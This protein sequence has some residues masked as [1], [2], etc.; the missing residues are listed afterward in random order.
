[1]QVALCLCA[2]SAHAD[3]PLD[4]EFRTSASHAELAR[5]A[6]A[7]SLSTR[8]ADT[9]RPIEVHALEDGVAMCSTETSY[10]D[11]IVVVMRMVSRG[12]PF[13]VTLAIDVPAS[14]SP[15]PA[16]YAALRV[17]KE[18]IESASLDALPTTSRPR[19]ETAVF[20]DPVKSSTTR[21]EKVVTAGVVMMTLA[22]IPTL[23]IG[24]A[25]A[26]STTYPGTSPV[27]P[28][29]PFVGMTV[30]SATYT[31]VADCNCGGD[32]A[33]SLFLSSLVNGVQIAGL[34]MVIVASASSKKPH[35]GRL[36]PTPLGIGGTF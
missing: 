34:V 13:V 4:A 8:V 25:I 24:G 29:V 20:V 21:I 16:D 35:V 33:L 26:G 2:A 15:S 28:F 36:F 27:W 6:C 3:A 11:A 12:D 18:A 30:F 32:R 10:P 17:A 1:M 7:M 22:S 14:S 23:F 9:T 31:E 5:R 19:S